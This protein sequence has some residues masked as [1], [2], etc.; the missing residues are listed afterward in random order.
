[1]NSVT[2]RSSFT[3]TV[4]GMQATAVKPPAAAAFVPDSMV[5]FH[6][7][8]GSRRWQCMSTNPGATTSPFIARTFASP[9]AMSWATLEITPSSQRTSST[10]SVF[11]AGSTTRPPLSKSFMAGPSREQI[12]DRHA[13]RDP[14]GDLVQDDGGGTVGDVAG[15]LDA[16]VDRPWVHHDRVA[17]R[18][19][20]P[21]LSQT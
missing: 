20:E 15:H 21:I 13:D 1:M 5:S 4:L 8:P 18:P 14:V 3:G 6:S 2:A 11:V 7:W 9:G 16:A 19:A 10:P 17:L 12:E